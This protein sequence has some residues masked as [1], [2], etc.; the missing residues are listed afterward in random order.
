MEELLRLQ[1]IVIEN[2]RFVKMGLRIQGGFEGEHDRTTGEPIPEHISA[3][4]QDLE[5][6]LSGLI[7]TTSI[8]ENAQF[9]PV[10][11]AAEIALA[12]YS[13]TRL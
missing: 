6:L 7:E 2:S 11:S 8:L 13:S 4:W 10:L 3:R 12:L 5:T 1:Q 9:H